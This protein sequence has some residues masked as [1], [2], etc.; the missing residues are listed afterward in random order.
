MC[1]NKAMTRSLVVVSKQSN[2]PRL[3]CPRCG[4][5]GSMVVL[6]IPHRQRRE[7]RA[8]NRDFASSLIQLNN[9]FYREY[10]ASFSDTRQAPWPGWVRTMDIALEQLDVA[11]IEHP[12]RVFD[13]ACGNMRFENFAAGGALAAKGVDGANPSADASCPFEF[14]GVDSCQDLAIDAHGHALRIPNLHFQELDVLDALMKL[15]PAETPDEFYGVDSC[16]D[17]AIDARGH[18]LRIPNL[19]FQELDALDA[20]MKLNPAETP[21]VL[22]DAPLADISVCFGF[23][24]HVPSCEYRV[25]VLDALVRQTRP[26][27]IIAI[28]FWEFMN[29]ERMARKA[30]R[31]E[32]RAEL[33]PPF[34]GYVRTPRTTI[35]PSLKPATTSLAGKTTATPTAIAITLTISRSPT[36]CAASV[37][38]TRAA[39]SPCVSLS[40]SMPT[41]VAASSTAM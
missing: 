40:A 15:N 33:T 27:G 38:S 17:L 8:V 19:H 26:G 6:F 20:L 13:L 12:V 37:R 16:Q 21:D 23:M 41:V 7:F 9:T 39:R 28:S 5:N 25:R 24:H 14:Y 30:V 3:G 36:W 22:F 11:T 10:S 31:A 4:V 34:E 32:A 29:D 2:D 18:A 35:P 1:P